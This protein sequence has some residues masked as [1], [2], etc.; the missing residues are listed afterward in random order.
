M[1]VTKYFEKELLKKLKTVT[2]KK[3]GEN[4]L[5]SRIRKKSKD[6]KVHVI[7]SIYR[8]SIASTKIPVTL[9]A[10]LEILHEKSHDKISVG[11]RS[12]CYI[13]NLK[14]AFLSFSFSRGNKKN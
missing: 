10:K 7:Q 2:T 5:R 12:K 13:Q 6:Q 11:P 9:F 4:P 14:V 1:I 3:E 8:L